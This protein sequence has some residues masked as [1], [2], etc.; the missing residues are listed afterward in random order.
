MQRKSIPA[1]GAAL[2]LAAATASAHDTWFEA[3]PARPGEA[4]FALGT[5][6]RFPLTEL[7][8]DSQYFARSGCRAGDGSTRALEALR[9]TDKTTVLRSKGADAAALACFVQLAPFEFE[10]PAD[11]IEIY[12]K[13]IRP[14]AAVR[15]AWAG[16]QARGLPFIERYTKSARIDLG[17][18]AAS[19]A[20]GTAMDA[21]RLAPVG[22]LTTGGEASFQVL[23]DG[24]PLADFPVELINERSPVGLW[25]RTDGEGRIRTRL[26]LP[27]RWLL[28]GTDLRLSPTDPT[29][30]QSQFITYAFTVA[31]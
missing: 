1:F 21:L 18:D 8:V 12:F 30:W 3:L 20:V 11:K 13:E 24:R 28:R 5:G 16:L 26:T 29:R 4:L 7:A 17:T 22:P 31:R 14:S 25:L 9:Y 10:L 6:N 15:A 19:Y 2:A 27:G 23:Q